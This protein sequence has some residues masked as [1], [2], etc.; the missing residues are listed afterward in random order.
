[1]L[2]EKLRVGNLKLCSFPQLDV[3]ELEHSATVL[4][5]ENTL[6]DGVLPPK[7]DQYCLFFFQ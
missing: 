5:S 7:K 2:S 1:M 6:T 4:L 3:M